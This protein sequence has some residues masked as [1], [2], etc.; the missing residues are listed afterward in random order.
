[1]N[2]IKIQNNLLT[3]KECDDV[4]RWGCDHIGFQADHNKEEFTGYDYCHLMDRGQDYVKC[5]SP[6]PLRPLYRAITELKESY[7]RSFYEVDNLTPWSLQYVRLKRWSP[8]WHYS[9]WHSEHSEL[10]PYRVI[11]FLIY[12]TDN[13]CSTQ[14]RRYRN[15]KTKAGRGLMFPAYFTH[16]HKGSVCKK[17]LTRY[18]ASGYFAFVTDKEE[19]RREYIP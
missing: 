13:D 15:V 10:E 9:S 1:M 8:E 7:I 3:R 19:W 16:E 14:F 18:I 5:F 4:I 11:S 6:E 12:L 17:G 2:F